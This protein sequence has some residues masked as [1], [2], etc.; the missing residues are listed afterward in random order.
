[1]PNWVGDV[2]MSTPAVRAIREAWPHVEVVAAVKDYAAPVLFKNPHIDR[3]LVLGRGDERP[4]RKVWGLARRLRRER[5]D[6][7]FLFTNSL[8]SALPLFLA[9]I[10]VRVGYA[11]DWRSPLL[12]HVERPDLVGGRR[13]PVPM[14][15]FYQRLLDRMGIPMAGS[16]YSVPV[17]ADE[18]EQA[19]CVL[20]RC[21]HDSG[22]PLVGLTP[23]A[24]FGASKL[25]PPE[26]FG[27][28]ARRLGESGIQTILLSGPG[29]EDLAAPIRD[30]AGSGLLDTSR[31]P[32]GLR[33][34][35]ALIERLTVL[36]STDSG[37]RHLAVAAGVPVVVV[38]GPTWPAWTAWNLEQT[39]VLRHDVPCGPCHLRTCP[40]DHACMDLITVDEVFS[41]VKGRI[42]ERMPARRE[43][44]DPAP[45]AA[46]EESR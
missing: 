5:F 34:L 11:G 22:R 43:N 16:H 4:V 33:L 27:D 41:A 30:H 10:P 3:L 24:R 2:V 7:A 21:G 29:E 32:V 38:M 37:P 15:L 23:G 12:T 9:R 26:R 45:P 35:S 14:P 46:E 18:R 13:Q 20:A 8:T 42:A 40:L 6:A 44:P 39:T 28:L 36:V 25:W 17:M 31:E 1:M 19:R